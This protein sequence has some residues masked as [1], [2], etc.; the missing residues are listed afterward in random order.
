MDCRKQWET[1]EASAEQ[2]AYE[3]LALK[4]FGHCGMGVVF[5]YTDDIH[6]DHLTTALIEVNDESFIEKLRNANTDEEYLALEIPDN[7]TL[8]YYMEDGQWNIANHRE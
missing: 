4:I 8:R 3:D 1:Q 7:E 2:L 5:D 6:L